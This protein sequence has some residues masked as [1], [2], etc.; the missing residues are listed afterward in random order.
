MNKKEAK[1]IQQLIWSFLPNVKPDQQ[2]EVIVVTGSS[3]FI[4]SVVV[5][6]WQNNLSWPL[7]VKFLH[8]PSGLL[9]RVD[10]TNHFSLD[11]LSM[12]ME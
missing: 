4:G 7:T 9:T 12:R 1:V 2:R 10:G 3:G 6:N 11:D 5:Q 8:T